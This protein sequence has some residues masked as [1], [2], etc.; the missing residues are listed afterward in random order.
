MKTKILSL[1]NKVLHDLG[2]D[3]LPLALILCCLITPTHQALSHPSLA[4]A[5]LSVWK[6]LPISITSI[7]LTLTQPSKHSSIVTFSGKPLITLRLG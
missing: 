3:L 4:W 5:L 2:L 1:A 6:V 7:W